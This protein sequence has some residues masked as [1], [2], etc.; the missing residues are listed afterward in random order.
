VELDVQ[1]LQPML[2][3]LCVFGLVSMFEASAH[4]L[5]LDEIADLSGQEYLLWQMLICHVD[6]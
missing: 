6:P 1:R 5:E 3:S 4:H 2:K